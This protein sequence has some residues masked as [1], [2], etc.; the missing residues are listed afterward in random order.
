MVIAIYGMGLM[1]GSFGRALIKYTDHKVLGA[2]INKDRIFKALLMNACH[3]Q[4]NKEALN[5]AD[6]VVLAV[7]LS[8]AETIMQE[9]TPQMKDGATIIDLCGLKQKI[10][11]TMSAVSKIYDKINFIGAHPMT[12]KEQSGIEHSSPDLYRESCFIMTPVNASLEAMDNIRKL[13]AEIGCV[14]FTIAAA[15][16]HDEI[17]AYT[18]QL[19]HVVSSAYIKSPA[20]L[21]HSGFSA[22]SFKDMT[23]V[24]CLDAEMWTEL[25]I[26]NRH[27]LIKEIGILQN[28]IELYKLA[29]IN[30]DKLQLKKLLIEG[31]EMKEKSDN[32]ERNNI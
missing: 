14:N 31:A 17:I 2:D 13:F 23:R 6:V 27:N 5:N 4:L 20:S 7:N 24:A 22:G 11:K 19:A 3:E 9:I 28:N 30:D 15:E 26:E 12:G 25:M 10:V 29:L 21:N 32:T 16:K 8:A 18:S 1:G